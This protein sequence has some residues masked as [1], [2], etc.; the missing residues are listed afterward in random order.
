VTLNGAV[1]ESHHILALGVHVSDDLKWSQHVQTIRAKVLSRLYFLK[2]LKRARAATQELI[3]FLSGILVYSSARSVIVIERG[4]C[5]FV[6]FGH[7]SV[8]K[9]LVTAITDR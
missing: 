3:S 2:Q 5:N 4:G 9:F 7:R 8:I 1:I 6:A